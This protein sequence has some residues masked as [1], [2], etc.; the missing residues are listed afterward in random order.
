M[1]DFVYLIYPYLINAFIVILVAIIFLPAQ[2]LPQHPLY[3]LIQWLELYAYKVHTKFVNSPKETF[4]RI[5]LFDEEF[6]QQNPGVR[7]SPLDR[8]ILAKVLD[9]LSTLNPKVVAIDIDIYYQLRPF[10]EE[11]SAIYSFSNQW[12]DEIEQADYDLVVSVN[13]LANKTFVILP[14]LEPENQNTQRMQYA[15]SKNLFY[16]NSRATIQ[17][18]DQIIYELP[19][20]EPESKNNLPGIRRLPKPSFAYAVWAA[21]NGLPNSYFLTRQIQQNTENQLLRNLNYFESKQQTLINYGYKISQDERVPAFRPVSA[22][23]FT[24]SSTVISNE[25]KKD[26]DNKIIL[27]G[28]NTFLKYPILEREDRYLTPHLNKR[29]SGVFLQGIFID[30][31]VNRLWLAKMGWFQGAVFGTVVS[32]ILG[33]IILFFSQY[34]TKNQ[35]PL[36]NTLLSDPLLSLSF[37]I[38]ISVIVTFLVNLFFLKKG[39]YTISFALIPLTSYLETILQIVGKK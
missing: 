15:E 5:I 21:Y 38:L 36:L 3:S 30:N 35:L 25:I 29:L 23:Y 37:G 32:I 34:T 6:F 12:L 18:P 28:R 17:D 9:N 22:K 20:W 1:S 24:G 31:F 16:G 13:K 27:I 14:L 39:I 8:K 33:W 10:L 2:Y 26:F 7:K 11:T 4:I 19:V